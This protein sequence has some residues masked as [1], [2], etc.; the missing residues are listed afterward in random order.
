VAVE[1]SPG[2]RAGLE[3]VEKLLT[4]KLESADM[5]ERNASMLRPVLRPAIVVEPVL[6]LAPRRP[7]RR[8][9]STVGK[10]RQALRSIPGLMEEVSLGSGHKEPVWPMP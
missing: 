5:T 6:A 4:T 8:P 1:S 7:G 10:L 2:R 3:F 9:L